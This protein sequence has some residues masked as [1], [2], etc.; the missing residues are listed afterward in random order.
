MWLPV[1]PLGFAAPA[2]TCGRPRGAELERLSRSLQVD[3][4]RVQMVVGWQPERDASRGH[5]RDDRLVSKQETRV[6]LS[7]P[8]VLV[9]AI[10]TSAICAGVLTYFTQRLN[11]MDTPN[12]RSSHTVPTPRGGGV[13]IVA[14][15]SVGFLVTAWARVYG[16]W[17]CTGA[18]GGAVWR[19]AIVGFA[20]DRYSVSN[21]SAG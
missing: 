10:A 17:A 12:R 21:A 8:I 9:I 5:R 6:S 14:T 3:A 13:A 1:V 20:D 11:L 16:L 18:S 2:C 4:S 7:V 15:S 19:F